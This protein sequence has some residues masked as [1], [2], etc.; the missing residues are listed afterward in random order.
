M[1]YAGNGAA[2]RRANLL[3]NISVDHLHS[4][5]GTCELS[6]SPSISGLHSEPTE[7]PSA[8][9]PSP[10]AVLAELELV[11]KSEVFSGAA[12]Q[13]RL[14]RHLVQKRQQGSVGD[15]KEY[16]LGVEVFDRGEDFDPRL[17]P[18]VRV[19]ASRLRSRLQKYYDGPG[20]NDPIRITLPR[21]AYVP[22]FTYPVPAVDAT[23]S[24]SRT[25]AV[26]GH[27][28]SAGSAVP[29][30]VK[31]DGLSVRTG[32]RRRSFGLV[33]AL[34]VGVAA[35][36]F[37]VLWTTRHSRAN[38][39]HAHF[40]NFK[41]ITSDGLRC[42]SPTFN[43]RGEILAYARRDAGTWQIYERDLK[44]SAVTELTPGA[45]QDN[46]EPAWSPDGKS[47]AFHSDRDGG[48]IFILDAKSRAI[49][50]LT[51]V[52]F[53]PSWSP[54]SQKLVFSTGTF[55]D[56][57]ESP[58]T[59]PSSLEVVDL[60]TKHIQSLTT[61]SVPSAQ[62]PSWSPHGERIAFWNTDPS[63]DR[64][65][66]TIAA[67]SPGSQ[68]VAVTHDAWT[69]WSPAWSPDGRYLYFSS[70]RGGAMNLW[71]VRIDEETGAV[72]GSVEPVTTPSSY[73]GWVTFAPSGEEFAYVRR[74][75]FSELYRSPFA[76]SKGIDVT[77]KV[78]LT[79]GEHSMHEPD[80]SPDGHWIAVRIQDPQEDLAIIHPDGTGLRRLTND[81]FSERDPRWSPN[82]KQIV[83]S[84]NRSGTFQLWSIQSDGSNLRQ[85]T[86]GGDVASAWSPDGVLV[87][88]PNNGSPF[89]IDPPGRP[90][91]DW[92]LP[93]SFR[94]IAWAPDHAAVTGRM[95]SDAFGRQALFV[96]VP[97]DEDFW[98]IAPVAP[99]PSTAW[100]NSSQ[101]LFS[102][103]DGI[104]LAD[105]HSHD[106][107]QALDTAH[108]DIRSRF[109]VSPDG[110]NVFFVESD[111]E[112]DIWTGSE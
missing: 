85:L 8:E 48:G 52:G 47:I 51:S 112:E 91:N 74:I 14:L 10:E 2:P 88:Y 34:L 42:T 75:P 86:T 93:S 102:R 66:Y 95:R 55:N 25:E 103:S 69:D 11:L 12:R 28:A 57:G 82:S 29:T 90:L 78:Q 94:P 31:S 100:L 77:Q 3:R 56:P 41:R 84:S 99:Y 96:F 43:P 26:T 105:L 106:L 33:P 73:T 21:G 79:F 63:G 60:T 22:A 13:Q 1:V 83:F 109:T 92:G 81:V 6:D 68:P 67:N 39:S 7:H 71:R 32:S 19:E 110:K 107:K 38:A 35:V 97:K 98:E 17:D 61:A 87:G 101:L 24:P 70:D 4:R 27:A 5:Q 64:D 9:I 50:R 30:E 36:G 54:D 20:T 76:P 37:V 49:S 44:T 62:Q 15:L 46:T 58:A 104:Y 108:T 72:K 80:M 16:T 111:D 89:A 40:L 65:I 53:Y 45:M 59:N 18:I 23:V